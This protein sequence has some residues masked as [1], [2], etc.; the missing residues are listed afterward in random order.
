MENFPKKR[1]RQ[2]NVSKYLT[3]REVEISKL[4]M[5]GSTNREIS[6]KFDISYDTTKNH[7]KN[8][9]SKTGISS[10][11][12]FTIKVFRTILESR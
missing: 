6:K 12:E 2:K 7:L 8:I 9:F 10:R 1:K 5:R 11:A 3:D 4:L